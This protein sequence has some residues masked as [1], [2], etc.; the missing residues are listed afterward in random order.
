[1]YMKDRLSRL[2]RAGKVGIKTLCLLTTCGLAYSCADEYA[3]DDSTPNWLGSSIYAT[4]QNQKGF[5]DFLKLIDDTGQKDILSRTGSKTLFVAKDDAFQQFYAENARLAPHEFWSNATSYE[6]LTDQQ[7]NLLMSSAMLDNPYLLEMLTSQMF[8]SSLVKGRVMR[9]PTSSK[10]ID[11][12]QHYAPITLPE[13]ANEELKDYWKDFRETGIDMVLDNTETMMTTFIAE[14]MTQNGITDD[15]FYYLTGHQ[16]VKSDVHVF[17]SKVI[18]QNITC[19]NG[20]I[21]IMDRVVA[22]RSNMAEVIRTNGETNIFSHMLERFS[23]PYYNDV[24]TQNYKLLNP[25]YTGKIYEKRYFAAN[26]HVGTKGMGYDYDLGVTGVNLGKDP[27]GETLP[28][29]SFLK[30]DPGWNGY[31]ESGVDNQMNMGAIF[32]PNDEAMVNYFREGGEGYN[33][34]ATYGKYKPFVFDDEG[35]ENLLK[36]LDCVPTKTLR[37]LIDN[38]MMAN[39]IASVPSK[40]GE[41]KD[42]ALDNLFGNED[43][44]EKLVKTILANNGA[45]YVLN[46]VISPADYISVMAPAYVSLDCNVFTWAVYNGNNGSNV[47]TLQYYTFLRTMGTQFSL[48]IPNDEALQYYYDPVSIYHNSALDGSF[49]P[50]I[51]KFNYTGKS[52]SAAVEAAAFAYDPLTGTIGEELTDQ[53]NQIAISTVGA[54]RLSDIME[55]HTIIHE[56]SEEATGL[57]S[58]NKYFMAKNGAPIEVLTKDGAQGK[59]VA[60]F[61]GGFQIE[62]FEQFG[63]K[64]TE[65]AT[66]NYRGL[67][68]VNVTKEYKQKNGWSYMVDAP[69]V[70]A[71]R[72]V[73]D[74]LKGNEGEDNPYSAFFELCEL[75][76][77]VLE[78]LVDLNLKADA[79]ADDKRIAYNKYRIFATQDDYDFYV[80]FFNSYNYTVYIPTNDQIEDAINKKKLPTWDELRDEVEQMVNDYAASED[81]ETYLKTKA[82]LRKKMDVLLKFVKCH[83][84]DVSI[85]A[86]TLPQAAKVYETS[87]F[88]DNQKFHRLMAETVDNGNGST[89]IRVGRIFETNEAKEAGITA[90]TVPSYG[91]A[92]TTGLSTNAFARDAQYG[93]K[94]SRKKGIKDVR[95]TTSSYAVI[96]Q[97]DKAL[98]PY[99]LRDADGNYDPDNGDLSYLWADDDTNIEESESLSF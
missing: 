52:G 11:F 41:V 94:V 50:R 54:N 84:Q 17:D 69:I 16:R 86:N 37:A 38:L 5:G 20:Y 91:W 71:T 60:G 26:A 99:L 18:K 74:V 67:T 64:E 59:E 31:S 42:S 96:H 29:G 92:S 23:A 73:Y 46:E 47:I 76:V 43:G 83:F 27:N 33:L 51:I 40:F 2:S 62:N 48:L 32:V 58:G 95:I 53:M 34:I 61:R 28:D 8:G 44:K 57:L 63:E 89:N 15:D 65:E 68:K 70:S 78:E 3:L 10:P 85:Y 45:I 82:R 36:N 93:N 72:S 22:P 81:E 1:M 21:N 55:S 49:T 79:S 35:H 88:N 14:Q 25:D 75:D 13:F 19:Q 97:I 87:A 90:E 6:N 98:Y 12:V 24:L 56:N 9:R 7:K 30:F 66:N 39:F 80:S 4:L 77:E